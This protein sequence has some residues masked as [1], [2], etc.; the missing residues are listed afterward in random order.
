MSR[1]RVA[2]ALSGGVD[3]SIAALLLKE[4]GY[5]VT[6]IYMRLWDCPDS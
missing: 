4:A 5:E 6:G 1:E 3:S 2:L